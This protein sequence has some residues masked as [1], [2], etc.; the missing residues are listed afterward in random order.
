[1]VRGH[2]KKRPDAE[3]LTQQITFFVTP[4]QF[5]QI[6]EYAM[7][8]DWSIAK[9]VRQSTLKEIKFGA[10]LAPDPARYR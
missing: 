7:K 2:Y 8:A 3:K 4:R 5:R 1:M 9:L 6:T 10:V